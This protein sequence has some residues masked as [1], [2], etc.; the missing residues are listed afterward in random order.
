MEWQDAE[1]IISTDLAKLDLEVIHR[2]LSVESYWSKGIK[3]EI[4]EAAIQ[5]SL[6]FGAYHEGKQIGFARMITDYATFAYLAD[7]FVLKPYRG[8]GLSKWLMTCIME[9]PKLQG[10]RR[11]MLATQDA[12]GLYAQFGYE[13]LPNPERFMQIFRPYKTS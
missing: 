11:F 5:N 12:H 10:L 1:F 3:R 8:R 13:P 7:V 4:I 6:C 9:H 2:F